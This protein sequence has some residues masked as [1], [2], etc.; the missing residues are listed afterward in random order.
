[1]LVDDGLTTQSHPVADIT[2]LQPGTYTITIQDAISCKS[3]PVGFTVS[4]VTA[5]VATVTHTPIRCA[6]SGTQLAK[7]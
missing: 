1:M 2:G 3:I 5:M 4:Q 6:S 7:Q